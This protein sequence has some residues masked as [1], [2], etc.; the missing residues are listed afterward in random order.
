MTKHT[1]P[2]SLQTFFRLLNGLFRVRPHAEQVKVTDVLCNEGGKESRE[3]LAVR[4]VIPT[5][6][7]ASASAGLCVPLFF[8]LL[9]IVSEL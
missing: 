5:I 4:L 6:R 7:A 9:F 2:R 3:S 1:A 8:L